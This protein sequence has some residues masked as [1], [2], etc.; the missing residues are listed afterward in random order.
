MYKNVP[1]PQMGR[2][3]H[4]MKHAGKLLIT[5]VAVG[6]LPPLLVAPLSPIAVQPQNQRPATD[7]AVATQ[8]LIRQAS[9]EIPEV[10]E[11]RL[12]ETYGKLPLSFEAN[13]G[14]TDSQVKF[15]SRRGSHCLFLSSTEAVLTLSK[16]PA[17]R[18]GKRDLAAHQTPYKEIE[19]LN[20]AE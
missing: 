9:E 3:D 17:H 2:K 12:L 13:Q 20:G 5:L 10:N 16:F 14:Q 4:T 7:T 6:I 11:Q 19:T 15:L 18:V 8:S 1:L